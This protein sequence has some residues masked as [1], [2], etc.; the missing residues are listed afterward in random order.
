ML[1]SEPILDVQLMEQTPARV[2]PEGL[3]C[4]PAFALLDVQDPT[5]DSILSPMST[6]SHVSPSDGS[7][8]GTTAAGNYTLDSSSQPRYL[9]TSA[10][11]GGSNASASS[12]RFYAMLL[13]GSAALPSSAA[14]S[15]TYAAGTNASS[16]VQMLDLAGLG[17]VLPR[18]NPR[19]VYTNP[20]EVGAPTTTSNFLQTGLALR[21]DINTTAEGTVLKTWLIYSETGAYAVL[22]IQHQVCFCC[23]IQ[24]GFGG[25][26]SWLLCVVCCLLTNILIC[27]ASS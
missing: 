15:E 9:P 16:I 6:S 7:V 2:H 10:P 3:F 21:A 26:A 17:L 12:H 11:L 14:G 8:N 23:R 22:P 25:P 27:E 4:F 5:A 20:S 18:G 24:L 19:G 13:P 1:A